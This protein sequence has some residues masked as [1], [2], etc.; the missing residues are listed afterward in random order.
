[1]RRTLPIA[2]LMSLTL[3]GAPDA[4]PR[5]HAPTPTQWYW[6]GHWADRIHGPVFHYP[7][8]W[9]ARRWV[10]GAV[11]PSI[12][13]TNLYFYDDW[14]ALGLPPPPPGARW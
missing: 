3:A 10:V 2:I 4:A 9:A 14:A 12:F 1:M 13:L 8:G 11:L 6:R 5:F 7:A